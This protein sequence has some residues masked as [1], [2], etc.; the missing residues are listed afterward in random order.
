M[1]YKVKY[2]GTHGFTAWWLG[3]LRGMTEDEAAAH[4]FTKEE[5]LNQTRFKIANRFEPGSGRSG[6]RLKLVP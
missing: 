6:V 5:L 1:R 2:I 3:P 4:I